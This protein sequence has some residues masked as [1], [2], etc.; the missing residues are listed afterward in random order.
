M[1]RILISYAT[2][3]GQ[4]RR[5]AGHIASTLGGLGHA[6]DCIDVAELS[7]Q[8]DWSRYSACILAASVHAGKHEPSMSRFVR[9][10]VRELNAL[11]TAFVSTSV[12]EAVVERASA[13]EAAR[14]AAAE[15]V[16]KASRDF[17]SETGWHPSRVQP[18]AGALLYGQYGW[19]VRL[20]VKAIARDQGLDT[21]TEHDH[22]YTDWARL[23]HFVADF[24]AALARNAGQSP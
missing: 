16:E 6:V 5:I 14:R 19:A 17:F 11:P 18:V 7:W 22:Q 3:E 24:S 2:R 15:R 1:K 12:A 4:T 23:E 13:S 8:L 10:H 9:E 21:D 20:I